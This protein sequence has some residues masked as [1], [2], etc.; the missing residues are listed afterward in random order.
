MLLSHLVTCVVGGCRE[1]LRALGLGLI[2]GLE[3]DEVGV[4]VGVEDASGSGV[5][6]ETEDGGFRLSERVCGWRGAGWASGR[7]DDGPGEA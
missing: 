2:E 3:A 4:E 7:G 5:D 6:I 1:A